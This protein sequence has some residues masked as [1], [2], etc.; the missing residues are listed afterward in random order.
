MYNLIYIFC[1]KIFNLPVFYFFKN[2]LVP[3]STISV[4]VYVIRLRVPLAPPPRIDAPDSV[5]LEWRWMAEQGCELDLEEKE[6]K[7]P[8]LFYSIEYL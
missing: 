3:P 4:I 5:W 7:S 2:G 8:S 1:K 6:K